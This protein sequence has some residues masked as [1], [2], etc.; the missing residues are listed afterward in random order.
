MTES[1]LTAIFTDLAADLDSFT[2]ATPTIS[3]GAGVKCR[4]LMTAPTG[5]AGATVTIQY[6]N[7][8]SGVTVPTSAV[9]PGG[10]NKVW[11]TVKVKGNVPSGTQI[12]MI[13]TYDGVSCPLTL[14][15]Q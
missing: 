8:V 4:V 7:P 12:N 5:P 3:P 9:I 14:T 1:S 10:T 15:V 11:I 6:L 2:G 13:A